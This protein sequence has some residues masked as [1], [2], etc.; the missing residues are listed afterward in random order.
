MEQ[1]SERV[2]NSPVTAL[3]GP[4][5]CGKTTLAKEYGKTRKSH[6]F[7]LESIADAN[8]LQNAETLL[9]ELDG[10]IILDEIQRMPGLFS[11]LRVLVDRFER[12]H[13]FLILGSANPSLVKGVSESLAGRVD[14]LDMRGFDLSEVG[15]EHYAN[16]WLRGGFPDSY[17]AHGDGLS[18]RRRNAFIRTHV[19][20]D[21]P[22]LGVSIPA[23]R[24]RQFWNMLAHAH[25]Q[26][27]NASRIARSMGVS[28]HTVRN[29]LDLL[30]G[31]Y[32]VRQI[33]PWHENFGKR[34]V[35]AP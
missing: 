9:G 34:Q 22:M 28:Y 31:T 7:D 4:K 32:M 27:W 16:L 2:E 3:L 24:I 19:E 1:L 11:V 29:Y 30:T 33:Q 18:L 35:K 5:Q 8:A 21:L 14:F 23:V 17:Y 20:R 15:S 6:Y 26:I 12:K 13:R 10:L 25:G